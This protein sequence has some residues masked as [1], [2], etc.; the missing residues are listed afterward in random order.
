MRVRYIGAGDDPPERCMY[1]GIPFERDGEPVEVTDADILAK[2]AGNRCFELLGGT[3]A[4]NDDHIARLPSSDDIRVRL[5]ASEAR[6]LEIE[7]SALRQ[8]VEASGRRVDGRWGLER[9]RAEA[10][11]GGDNG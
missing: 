7:V 3:R 4:E 1:K 6:A 8:A 2:L 11:I 9:L 5:A 10:T